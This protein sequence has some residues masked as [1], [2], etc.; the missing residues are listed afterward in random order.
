MTP[1]TLSA[2]YDRVEAN[3]DAPMSADV[4]ALLDEIHRLQAHE[5]AVKRCRRLAAELEQ[6]RRVGCSGRLWMA[7]RDDKWDANRKAVADA[8]L[9][10]MG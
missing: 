4:L 3:P 8:G 2:I 6:E 9:P 1:E 7:L 5:R 10:W